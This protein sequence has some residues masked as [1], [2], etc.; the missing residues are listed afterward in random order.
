[1]AIIL[2]ARTINGRTIVICNTPDED[3]KMGTLI[4][5]VEN[6][7]VWI[8]AEELGAA[9]DDPMVATKLAD[10]FLV[11]GIGWRF[12]ALG[13]GATCFQMLGAALRQHLVGQAI[14]WRDPI[15]TN[16]LT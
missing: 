13:Y 14:F 3:P 15:F 16:S 5:Q 8:D 1:M 11:E 7:S 9:R 6:F 2:L 12:A 10:D 4:G